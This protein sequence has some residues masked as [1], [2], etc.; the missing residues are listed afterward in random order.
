MALKNEKKKVDR[1]GFYSARRRTT[2]VYWAVTAN[3]Y[4]EYAEE[5]EDGKF[6]HKFEDAAENADERNDAPDEQ[7]DMIIIE[8]EEKPK[9]TTTR[10][11]K[12]G[13]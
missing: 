9:V 3:M 13:K 10:K 6:F 4:D 7:E 8:P 12:T 1:K 11:T 2:G 5:F